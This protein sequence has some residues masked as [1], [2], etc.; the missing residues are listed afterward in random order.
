MLLEACDDTKNQNC[1]LCIHWPTKKKQLQ[2]QGP[3][4]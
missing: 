3:A 2:T 1:V 4:N